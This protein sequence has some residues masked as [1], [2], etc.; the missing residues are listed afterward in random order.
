MLFI[1]NT[2]FIIYLL[3]VR[4]KRNLQLFIT[5]YW[6]HYEIINIKIKKHREREIH[7]L[8]NYVVLSLSLFIFL[9][10]FSQNVLPNISMSFFLSLSFH[11]IHL[12]Q[13]EL[14]ITI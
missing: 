10:F 1:L 5:H 12:Y 14:N 3:K 11:Y 6:S 4:L 8:M 7:N 13:I 9:F 2:K